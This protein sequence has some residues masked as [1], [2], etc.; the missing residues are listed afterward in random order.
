MKVGIHLQRTSS[1]GQNSPFER[2]FIDILKYNNIEYVFLNAN[3]KNFWEKIKDI[4]VFIFRF[5][6]HASEFQLATSLLPIIEGSLNIKCFPNQHSCWHFDDKIKQYYLSKAYHVPM[7]ES[8]I[9]WDKLKC[10]NWL[11]TITFPIVFKLKGGAGSTNVVLL[12]SK[13]EAHKIVN[14]IF[15]SGIKSQKIP[16]KNSLSIK[17]FS[18]V[19]SSFEYL[20]VLGKRIKGLETTRFWSPNIGYALFQ[21]Y[22]P[23]N[24]FDTRVLTV[25]KRAFAYRRMNRKNDFRSSGSGQFDYDVEKIDLKH[26]KNAFK[27]SSKLNFQ[28]MAYDFLYNE[29][30]ESET[31]E[32]SYT[33]IDYLMYDCAG[34]WDD[35]LNWYPGHYWPQYFILMDLLDQP[36]LKQ[37]ELKPE[38]YLPASNIEKFK[39]VFLTN[40]K[41]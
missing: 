11:E 15:T 30:G 9:F 26:I 2:K 29:I 32:M 25:G 13:K 33:T 31:C 34:Y 39:S 18:L 28:S 41:S 22:L 40:K 16:V 14:K 17:N 36:H 12:E 37:P 35:K 19:K 24:D 38:N 1:S 21:K 4:D 20:K 7:T 6:D 3:D 23:N 8:W 5:G 27:I 10:I